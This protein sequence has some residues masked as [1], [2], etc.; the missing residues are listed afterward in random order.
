MSRDTVHVC[1]PHYKGQGQIHKCTYCYV[2]YQY[3]EAPG[4]SLGPVVLNTV[5]MQSWAGAVDGQSWAV[6]DLLAARA[7]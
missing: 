4:G 2:L 1:L 6:T 7:D 3:F 5:H